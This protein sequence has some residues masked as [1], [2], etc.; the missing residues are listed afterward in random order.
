[1]TDEGLRW[2]SRLV[3][4]VTLDLWENM[5]LTDRVL[6]E[7]SSCLHLETV[8]V[9]GRTF[10]DTGV[11]ALAQ[12]CRGICLPPPHSIGYDINSLAP[13]SRPPLR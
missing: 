3:D 4:L 13:P 8:R 1:M 7:A 12:G 6:L 10:T 5:R 2:I 11:C 9:C